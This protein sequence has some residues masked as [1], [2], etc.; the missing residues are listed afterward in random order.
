MILRCQ[1]PRRR[2]RFDGDTCGGFVARLPDALAPRLVGLV[3]HS[4]LSA[5]EHLT[6]ACNRCGFLHEV[7]LDALTSIRLAA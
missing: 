5:P 3:A 4:D 2:L 6:M 7:A 1:A